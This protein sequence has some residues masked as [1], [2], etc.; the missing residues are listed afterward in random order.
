MTGMEQD[1]VRPFFGNQTRESCPYIM[2]SIH[3]KELARKGAPKYSI[4]GWTSVDGG[5]H[6]GDFYTDEEP[7]KFAVSYGVPIMFAG[8]TLAKKA[9]GRIAVLNV[10]PMYNLQ[11][12]K[13]TTT[14]ICQEAFKV[15]PAIEGAINWYDLGCESA[16]QYT[17]DTGHTGYRVWIE[18]AEPQAIYLIE[19]VAQQLRVYG[20]RD[21]EIR[22][23][24]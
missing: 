5:E 3:E 24:W 22:T 21:V 4:W 2:V 16:E 10:P 14:K 7:H 18:E 13:E 8:Q 19:F 23:E 17:D 1:A 6:L 15:Q 20:F 11:T 9:M 12:L